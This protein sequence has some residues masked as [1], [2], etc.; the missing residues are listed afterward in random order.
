MTR[1]TTT[2][3][4]TKNNPFVT[5]LLMA[6]LA[7]GIVYLVSGQQTGCS[8]TPF[9]PVNPPPIEAEGLRVLIVEET[10]DRHKL[11]TSQLAVLTSAKLSEWLD[12]NCVKHDG[13]PEWR[14]WDKDTDISHE[15]SLWQSA[16]EEERAELPWLY[17]SNGQTGYSGPLPQTLDETFE[18][19]EKY[20]E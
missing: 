7:V 13:H 15:R 1:R 20:K 11:P 3:S 2:K 5:L 4:G 10:A 16:F 8:F 14:R 6:L 17:V 19:L 12:D 18:I 9:T